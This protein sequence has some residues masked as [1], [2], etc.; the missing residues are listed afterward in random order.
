M[1]LD[2]D[3]HTKAPG[4]G[5][6]S[7]ILAI[8]PCDLSHE[9]RLHPVDIPEMKVRTET[10]SFRADPDLL[11]LID[12]QCQRFGISRGNWVRGVVLAHLHRSA[13]PVDPVDL[14]PVERK[15]DGLERLLDLLKTDLARSLFFVLTRVGEMPVGEAREFVRSKFTEHEADRC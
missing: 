7:L 15:L 8:S 4:C 6:S 5:Q 1:A 2:Y 14:G 13:N 10:V 3:Q 12:D 11:K 9:R